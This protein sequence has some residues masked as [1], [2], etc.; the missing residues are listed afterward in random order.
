MQRQEPP[1]CCRR[2]GSAVT[3]PRV[4]LPLLGCLEKVRGPG[5]M[6]AD[7]VCHGTHV[8]EDAGSVPDP[9]RASDA[10]RE[11]LGGDLPIVLG[12]IHEGAVVAELARQPL[13]PKARVA[14]VAPGR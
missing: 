12:D 2:P 11:Q 4:G 10:Q 3:G 6:A 1:G 9:P 7:E 5:E 14:R 13:Q 8:A